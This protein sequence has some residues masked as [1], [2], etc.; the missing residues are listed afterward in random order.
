MEVS[1]Q[2]VHLHRSESNL[3]SWV[4]TDIRFSKKGNITGSCC[5]DQMHRVSLYL[6]WQETDILG[7]YISYC[8]VKNC[9]EKAANQKLYC[10]SVDIEISR[11]W[12]SIGLS[13]KQIS[14]YVFFKKSL[15]YQYNVFVENC[16]N[17]KCG[18]QVINMF[19]INFRCT[20][21]FGLRSLSICMQHI[22]FMTH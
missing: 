20:I 4:S 11:E 14:K 16:I 3:L 18:K 10:Q 5:C 22:R 1:D 8:P 17:P 21:V 13:L 6:H 7:H 2:L 9:Y 19:V 12:F 15:E